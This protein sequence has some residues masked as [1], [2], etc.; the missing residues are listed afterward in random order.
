[1]IANYVMKRGLHLNNT[2][3]TTGNH[4]G[5]DA[6]GTTSTTTHNNK[7]RYASPQTQERY[8]IEFDELT[9]DSELNTSTVQVTPVKN[10]AYSGGG[11]GGVYSNSH[12]YKRNHPLVS[13]GDLLED[14]EREE[15]EETNNNHRNGEVRESI[16]ISLG[17]GRYV[18]C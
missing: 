8:A 4:G 5:G 11:G 3:N 9:M 12:G 17:G 14:E 13:F 10:S 16:E 18:I 1:M 15:E 2:T 6:P 7:Y